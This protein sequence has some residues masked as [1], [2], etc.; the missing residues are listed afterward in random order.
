[1][2]AV[3]MAIEPAQSGPFQASAPAKTD[4]FAIFVLKS[5][6]PGFWLTAIWFYLFPVAQ[7]PVLTT[8]DFWFGVFYVAF[9]FG[10]LIYGCNDI[11]DAEEDA[12]NPR[13]GNFLFGGRGSREQLRRLPYAIL[14]VHGLCAAVLLARCGASVLVWYLA[15]MAATAMYNLPRLGFKQRPVL[16]VLNQ[17]GYILVFEISSMLNG[18]PRLPWQSVMFGLSF[19][20]HSHLLGEIMDL[21]PDQL[22][23]RRTTAIVLGAVRTKLLIALMLLGEA[24]LVWRAFD[25]RTLAM[26]LAL[27][28]FWFVADALWVFGTRPYPNWIARWFLL[29]WNVVAA[30][31]AWFIYTSGALSRVR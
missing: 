11:A 13:K 4:S 20:M 28:S 9:P 8:F 30:A 25:Q 31:T 17:A 29:G 23:G 2:A 14:G 22:A 21:Q 16:D 5:S 19:A 1:M 10:L 7:Q 18:V 27:A 6:R 24:A 26:M 3:N 12:L 15:L